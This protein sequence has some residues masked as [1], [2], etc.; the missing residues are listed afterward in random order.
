[1]LRQNKQALEKDMAELRRELASSQMH[2]ATLTEKLEYWRKKQAE[3][4]Q[5]SK[6]KFLSAKYATHCVKHN[7]AGLILYPILPLHPSL[8]P[9]LPLCIVCIESVITERD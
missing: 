1:M 6:E 2:C 4:S 3:R 7:P 9:S 5:H 8:P